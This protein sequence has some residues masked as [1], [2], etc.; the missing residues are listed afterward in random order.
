MRIPKTAPSLDELL[1]QMPSAGTSWH[2]PRFRKIADQCQRSYQHWDK[3]RYIAHQ[4]H[5]DAEHLWLHL[6]LGRTGLFRPVRLHG[7][8]GDTVQFTVPDTL[9]QEIMQIDRFLS[10]S[11][12]TDDETPLSK[13][14]QEYFIIN[15]LQEEA[16]ASSMLM[17]VPS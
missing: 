9:Q 7:A 14:Q 10:G 12:L 6:L 13:T 1:P 2:D 15:S 4:E 8:D 5:L 11:L 3:V 16:I 17:L